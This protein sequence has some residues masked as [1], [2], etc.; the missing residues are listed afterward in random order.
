MKKRWREVK[1]GLKQWLSTLNKEIL[2]SLFTFNSELDNIIVYKTPNQLIAEIDKELEPNG[3][4]DVSWPLIFKATKDILVKPEKPSNVDLKWVNYGMVFMIE[5]VEYLTDVMTDF[6]GFKEDHGFKY[7]FN[8]LT[9]KE[10]SNEVVKI[11]S[12]LNGACY[13]TK[14]ETDYSKA[15]MQA[16]EFNPFKND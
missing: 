6:I 2:V 3:N 5:N 7:F 1:Y 10:N 16:L 15:F 11:A 9:T 12:V 14:P 8:A 4:S 13:Y